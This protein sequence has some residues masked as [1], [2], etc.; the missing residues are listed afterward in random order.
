[1]DRQRA[2]QR[3]AVALIAVV[4]VMSLFSG[5]AAA[6]T[7]AGGTVIVQEGETVDGLS[8]VAGTVVVRGTV[9]GN[10]EGA[11][12]SVVIEQSG[13]VTGDLS[14]A[15]GSIQIAGQVQG[16]VEAGSGSILVARSGQ[17]DGSLKGGAGSVRIEGAIGGDAQI[18]AASLTLAETG[19]IGGDLRYAEE[20]R[21]VNNGGSV[22]GTI[23][24]DPDL[25]G[26]FDL[27][28]IPG[29]VFS[30]Y[31]MAVNLAVG[32][33]LLIALPGFSRRVS[34]TG[35]TDPLRSG[36]AGLVALIG[37]P[38]GLILLAITIVGIP[39]TIVGAFLFVLLL[40]VSLIYGRIT[41]GAWALKQVDV[42]NRWLALVV[43]VVGLGLLGQA[44]LIGG[45]IDLVTFLLG[46]GAITL[47]LVALRRGGSDEDEGASSPGDASV[48]DAAGQSP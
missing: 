30:G 23:A 9:D 5:V 44:P 41:I 32:A 15:A 42:D 21:F 6:E 7:R 43:G 18:G 10:L 33:L 12:G 20:T 45:L 22:G 25:G 8:A 47:V 14:I 2:T 31:A 40:W 24:V 28:D 4:V 48:D 26:G 39:L 36:G 17:I 35:T 16:D 3:A 1:M 19:S 29:W 34:D 46:L 11:A 38:I 37:I 27:V 13:V